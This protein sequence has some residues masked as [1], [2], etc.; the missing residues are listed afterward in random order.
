MQKDKNLFTSNSSENDTE[1]DYWFSTESGAHI[2]VKKGQT[3]EQALNEFLKNKGDPRG[4]NAKELKQRQER[5]AKLEKSYNDELT[6][7]SHY[8]PQAFARA[9]RKR[10]QTEQDPDLRTR[11]QEYLDDVKHE[12]HI[13]ADLVLIADDIDS[14]LLGY[15]FRL[16]NA[17]GERFYQKIADEPTKRNKDNVRY[18]MRLG[19]GVNEYRKTIDALK[20]KGYKPLAVKN[21]WLSGSYY[22]GINTQWESPDGT[23]FE[24]QFHSE[25]NLAV[26]EELHPLYERERD[27]KTSIEE[28]KAARKKQAEISAKFKKPN[29]IE[30]VK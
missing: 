27:P 19:D 7:L 14:R 24:I 18:T 6:G 22:K 12:P 30:E 9:V 23:M 1:I 10:L 25:H 28:K 29:G 26:K 16:K 11:Y 8:Q 2:P 15:Q 17:M 5:L 3:K 21:Y 20:H 4:Q 13:S